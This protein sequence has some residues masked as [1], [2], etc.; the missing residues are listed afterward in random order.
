MRPVCDWVVSSV[1]FIYDH[2]IKLKMKREVLISDLISLI[3][4]FPLKSCDLNEFSTLTESINLF[5]SLMLQRVKSLLIDN[6]PDSDFSELKENST[7]HEIQSMVNNSIK[8]S[9]GE[10]S[11]H[12]N[13]NSYIKN[14]VSPKFSENQNPSDI[15]TN[16]LSVGIDIETMKIF[17]EDVMGPTGSYFRLNTFSPKEIAYATTRSSP[18]QTLLGIFCAKEAVIKC[19]HNIDRLSFRDIEIIHEYKGSPLCKIYSKQKNNIKIS[20]S[21][22]DDY[23]CAFAVLINA[24]N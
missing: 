2:P 9:N 1:F 19:F 16:I 15:G 22:T 6:Y 14:K 3:S 21:H 10:A 11:D 18:V 20:I 7:I 24:F 5:G 17:P 23:A 8:K 4:T 12:S 13:L